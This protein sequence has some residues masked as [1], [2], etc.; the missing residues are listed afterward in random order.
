MKPQKATIIALA[1]ILLTSC[2]AEEPAI[3]TESVDNLVKLSVSVG[4]GNSRSNPIGTPEQQRTFNIGDTIS[5]SD[6]TTIAKYV[7]NGTDWVGHN[8]RYLNWSESWPANFAAKHG[9]S[10]GSEELHHDFYTWWVPGRQTTFKDLSNADYMLGEAHYDAMP[11]DG[12][13]Q[14]V[15]KRKT[16]RVIVRIKSFNNEFDGTN[17][18]VTKVEMTSGAFIPG[19]GGGMYITSYQQGDGGV[20]TTY[21]ALISPNT[22]D[23]VRV[24]IADDTGE[25]I[26]W[27]TT[28]VPCEEGKSYTVDLVVGKHQAIVGG[29][30]VSDW[31]DG[32]V[33]DDAQLDEWVGYIIKDDTYHIYNEKGLYNFAKDVN[34]GNR[35]AGNAVLEYDIDISCYDHW[36]PIGTDENSHIFT[37]TFDGKG[38]TI[39]GLSI[40]T[41]AGGRNATIGLFGRVGA[42]TI[43]NVK[44]SGSITV[45][46]AQHSYIGG[47]IGYTGANS[48]IT[49]CHSN[50]TITLYGDNVTE[51]GVGGITGILLTTRNDCRITGCYN[52]GKIECLNERENDQNNIS[53][54]I[55]ETKTGGYGAYAYITGC[56]NRADIIHSRGNAVTVSTYGDAPKIIDCFFEKVNTV[57]ASTYGAGDVADTDWETAMSTMNYAIRSFGYKYILGDTPEVPLVIT[58]R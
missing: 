13:I 21:T 43:T 16:A 50:V 5:V 52:T 32:G 18:K 14:L 42:C 1:T 54:I 36:T 41:I 33:L 24:T 28:N 49:A 34:S 9:Y 2:A 7:Y 58:N 10:K 55:G 8:N 51:C 57:I 6:G 30:T 29:V 26:I 38:H 19:T 17:P 27:A 37:G 35:Q 11:A 20:G 39:S 15:M 40:D 25:Q 4:P 3:N 23:D 56:Y 44:V 46:G 53:G 45:R 47:I 48:T 22:M 31:T 12:R